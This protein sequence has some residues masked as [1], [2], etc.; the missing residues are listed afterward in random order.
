MTLAMNHR[1]ALT[2][3]SPKK[4]A[5]LVSYQ[6]QPQEKQ[7]A[8]YYNSYATFQTPKSN[9]ILTK[10]RELWWIQGNIHPSAK[11]EEASLPY[12]LKSDVDWEKYSE[13]TDMFNVHGSWE[14]I[15]GKV[16]VYELPLGPHETFSEAIKGEIRLKDPER[17]LIALG[18]VLN[19][20]GREGP[21]SRKPW[22]DL[23]IEVASSETEKHLLSAVKD[24][25]LY[26]GRAHDAIAVNLVRS[27]TIISKIKI[28]HFCTND[29]TPM[30]NLVP[31]SKFEFE[32]I[33]DNDQILIE[34]QQY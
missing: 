4:Q 22:P 23:A 9:D 10:F 19:S 8:N 15:D 20:N 14:W 30:G 11:W 5:L 7:I 32:T 21:N 33:D 2:V 29:R 27:G 13:R 12:M 16:Y 34:P 17:M 3:Q 18:S 25:W 1:A 28:W 26:P 6:A 24:Y 31:I